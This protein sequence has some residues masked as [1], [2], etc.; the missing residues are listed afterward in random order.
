[1][2]IFVGADHRGFQLKEALVQ[3]LK[4]KGLAVTDSGNAHYDQNDDY[5]DFAH[6]V[7]TEVLKNPKEHRGIV[8]CG[9]GVGVSIVANRLK[10][11]RCALGF[12][13]TQVTHARAHDHINVLALPSDYV[14]DED[15]KYIVD[16]FLNTPANTQ[17]RH[18]RRIRKIEVHD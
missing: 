1:M 10:N 6:A 17:E 4:G 16:L 8:I 15:A 12:D 7:A 11:V 13:P 2:H 3:H 14:S 5:P 18:V 9:S